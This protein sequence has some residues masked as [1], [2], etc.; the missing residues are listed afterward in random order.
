MP[1]LDYRGRREPPLNT[2][3]K[4]VKKMKESFLTATAPN[5]LR[6]TLLKG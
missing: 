6:I 3:A 2:A 1:S 4:S 5:K